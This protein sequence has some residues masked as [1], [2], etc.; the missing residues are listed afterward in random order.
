MNWKG[1][2]RSLLSLSLLF[3]AA[4]ITPLDE[5]EAPDSLGQ[6]EAAVIDCRAYDTNLEACNAA[7]CAYYACSHSCYPKG[8]STYCTAGCF[9]E[10]NQGCRM[11]DGALEA[12]NAAG[13]AYY[14]CSNGCF[15]RDTGY[16]DAGCS[17]QCYT[18][19]RAAGFLSQSVPSSVVAGAL[20]NATVTLTN[21]GNLSW[22]A[23]N[24]FRLGSQSPQDNV[25]WGKWR[26]FL[27]PSDTIAKGQQKTFTLSLQ[28]P[29]TPGVYAFQWRMV[30]DGFGW[31]GAS[32]PVVYIQVTEPPPG[33]TPCP[34]GQI[35][36]DSCTTDY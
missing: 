6:S 33:C 13:C 34:A 26:I 21:T 12:C 18:P 25:T 15:I 23:V 29:S 7:G 11:H 32:T 19:Q 28:A 1:S 31:F 17:Y 36:Q 27:S 3:A 35:C 9:N 4:C 16:C 22:T 14:S 5:S 20:F 24:R 8:T 30:H 10:C 2:S